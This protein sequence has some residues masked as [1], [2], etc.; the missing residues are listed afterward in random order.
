VRGQTLSLRE[1][2]FVEAA[3]S[4][5]SRSRYILFREL[6]PNLAA[7][8]LVYA[9]L[10]IPVNIVFEAALSFLGVGVLPPKASWGKMLANAVN[11]YQFDPL[12]MIVPGA[13]LFITVL[14]FNLFGDGLRDALD[15]KAH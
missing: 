15:P 9:T 6:L 14:S 3:R 7:P 11:Y 1:R 4:M 5:G 8:I 13:M 2:E 12:Y 10:V